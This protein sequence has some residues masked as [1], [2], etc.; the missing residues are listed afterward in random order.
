LSQIDPGQWTC[1]DTVL[2]GVSLSERLHIAHKTIDEFLANGLDNNKA[3]CRNARLSRI[4]HARLCGYARGK[5]EV[6]VVQHKKWVA[7]TQLKD[8]LL[9]ILAR[10][11]RDF[12]SRELTSGQ[13]NGSNPVIRNDRVDF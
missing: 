7:S 2:Q 11:S 13:R 1:S 6:C 10:S 12:C 8:C 5:V 9:Q 4:L 3:L